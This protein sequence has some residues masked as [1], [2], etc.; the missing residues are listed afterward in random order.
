LS[1]QHV[2]AFFLASEVGR[3]KGKV[4][5]YEGSRRNRMGSKGKEGRGEKGWM[6]MVSIASFKP[7]MKAQYP[8]SKRE[9]LVP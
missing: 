5:W 9:S 4:T 3:E 7:R 8:H 1:Y 2:F 6:P